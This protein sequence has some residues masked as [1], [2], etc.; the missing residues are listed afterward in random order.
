MHAFSRVIL[1]GVAIACG[2]APASAQSYPSRAIEMIVP[3][4]AGGI[5]DTMAQGMRNALSRVLGQPVNIV[6]KDGASGTLG[7]TDLTRAAPDGYTIAFTSNNTLA[8]QPHVQKLPYAVGSFR[9]ICLG[10]YTPLV[11][12]AGPQAPFKTVE[13]FVAFAKAKPENL[14]YGYPGVASQQH[15]GMLGVLKAIGA[16]AR[17]VP[18]TSGAAALR[19]LFD[20]TVMAII[21][22]PGVATATDFPVLAALSEERIG[23]LPAVRTMKEVGYPATAFLAGGIIAPA[24]VTVEVA[25]RLEKA[26]AEAAA[27]ADYKSIAARTNIEA[28]HLAGEA[29]KKMMEK[30]WAEN[31]E[32]LARAGLRGPK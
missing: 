1:V 12:V 30:D 28:R 6:N 15:L 20:G 14:V 7:V 32:T 23:T 21:E 27:S 4:P 5:T 3:F 29:F 19:A 22:T 24:N 13:E 18:F 31:D 9:Y 8:A 16:N 25:D 2:T 17:G 11:L 10:Y 26:C